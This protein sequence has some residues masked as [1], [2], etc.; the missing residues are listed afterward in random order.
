[1]LTRSVTKHRTTTL[2]WSYFENGGGG[3]GGGRWKEVFSLTLFFIVVEYSCQSRAKFRSLH[4][5]K[6]TDLHS[7][8]TVSLVHN[9][10]YE[11]TQICGITKLQYDIKFLFTWRIRFLHVIDLRVCASGHVTRVYKQTYYGMHFAFI[12]GNQ[13]ALSQSIETEIPT[14]ILKI[15]FPPE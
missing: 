15:I 1:M 4:I 9:K 8:H 2:P 11:G 12:N 5:L 7:T 13:E 10:L 14:Y 3:G 6:I